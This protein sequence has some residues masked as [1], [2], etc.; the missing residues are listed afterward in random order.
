[1]VHDSPKEATELAKKK[2]Q[3]FHVRGPKLEA[4][5]VYTRRWLILGV[6]AGLKKLSIPTLQKLRLE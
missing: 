3:N 1:L 5:T 2:L 6:H 4:L